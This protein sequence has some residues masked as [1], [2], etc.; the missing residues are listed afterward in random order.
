MKKLPKENKRT[1]IIKAAIKLF[2]KNGFEATST[3]A[4]CKLAE[5]NISL[6]AYYFGGKQELYDEIINSFAQK[7]DVQMRTFVDPD[8]DLSELSVKEKVDMIKMLVGNMMNY[9]YNSVSYDMIDII[10]MEQQNPNTTISS[11]PYNFLRKILGSIFNQDPDS[12][13][14]VYKAVFIVLQ[15]AFVRVTPIF[16]LRIFKQESFEADDIEYIKKNLNLAIKALFNEAGVN[17]E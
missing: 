4:I 7:L 1:K 12:K 3:R 5:A 10:L 16:S 17:Y 9:F 6:I 13:D 2:A 8:M 11:P 15:I 14:I